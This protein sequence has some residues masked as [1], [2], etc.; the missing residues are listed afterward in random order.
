MMHDMSNS[1]GS[2]QINT[3]ANSV[4]LTCAFIER[5]NCLATTVVYYKDWSQRFMCFCMQDLSYYNY[6]NVATVV[7]CRI[8]YY[9]DINIH[10]Y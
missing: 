6:T 3:Q 1:Y 9:N 5:M 7:S 10:I 8:L 2:S 4:I